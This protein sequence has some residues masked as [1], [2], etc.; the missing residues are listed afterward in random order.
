M[1]KEKI[2]AELKAAMLA[3]DEVK[4]SAL[5]MLKAAVM[6][7]EVSGGE[8]KEATDEDVM[9]LIKKELKSRK[10]SIDQFKAGGRE[11]LVVKEE[12]EIKALEGYL[13]KQM[14]EDEV[15]AVV[16][17]V[18]AEMGVGGPAAMGKVMGACMGKLKG[19]A[20]GTMVNKLVK[21]ML[22]NL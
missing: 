13:P 20:D 14:S 16:K 12:A 4:V 21:E 6:K 22:G 3:R 17:Q 8:K 9:V 7:F 1:L 15:R 5:R 19:Q 18:V 11:D 10:D 2:N